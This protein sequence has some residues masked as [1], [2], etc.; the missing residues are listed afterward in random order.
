[1]SEQK[2]VPYY[3]YP[4]GKTP[5]AQEGRC[6]V[7]GA[8][9]QPMEFEG[10]PALPISAGEVW[11]SGWDIPTRYAID[12][13]DQ[14]W[15]DNAHGHPLNK[16]SVGD[17]LG[18]FITEEYLATRISYAERLGVDPKVDKCPTCGHMKRRYG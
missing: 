18:L 8:L 1:M 5:V 2:I 6:T 12:A 3:L 10:E 14:C 16:I 15:A 4:D 7:E 11:H 9:S 13:D 17:F